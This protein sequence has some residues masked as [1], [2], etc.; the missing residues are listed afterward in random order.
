MNVDK[1]EVKKTLFY[2]EVVSWET[3]NTIKKDR[4]KYCVTIKM[5]FSSGDTVKKQYGTTDT[6]AEARK[7]IDLIASK[8]YT[9]SFVP[10]KY[11][12]EEFYNYWLYWYKLDSGITYGTYM[13]YRNIT[14]NYILP[15][16]GKVKINTLTSKDIINFVNDMD[17]SPSLF[18]QL[19]GVLYSSFKYARANNIVSINPIPGAMRVLNSK[20]KPSHDPNDQV[21][22]YSPEQILKLLE[23]ARKY[24]NLFIPC[25]LSVTC[26]LRISEAL[27]VRKQDID[28]EKKVLHVRNQIGFAFEPVNGRLTSLQKPKTKSSIRD[29]PLSDNTLEELTLA[30]KRNEEYYKR[31]PEIVDQGFLTVGKEGNP[32]SRSQ[33]YRAY[34]SAIEK[35]NL[36]FLNYHSLRHAFASILN[37]DCV[38][39]KT[40]ANSM[41][42]T[43]TSMTENVYIY[44][45]I[46]VRDTSIVM[47]EFLS[48]FEI[49]E[50]PQIYDCEKAISKFFDYLRE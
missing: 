28:F 18:K 11:T 41:G 39:L 29:I 26:G 45:G 43:S 2:G 4:G 32:F 17:L 34:H 38:N 10:F 48:S 24:D 7:A 36:P 6:A 31:H 23:A 13:T 50:K 47:N 37:A 30:I 49:D 40:I 12:C 14:L 20:F 21:K 35:A 33:I 19:K 27:A 44:K 16:L 8:L 46:E 3:P 42:H 5:T 9:K 25:L 22:V 15:T 1:P